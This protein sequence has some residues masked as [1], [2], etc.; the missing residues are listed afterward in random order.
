MAQPTR[1]VTLDAAGRHAPP[2]PLDPAAA[3][4]RLATPERLREFFAPRSIALVGASDSSGWG[5]FVVDSL[6]TAGFT[7]ALRPVHPKH[8]TAFD[9]PTV[10]SLRALDAPVDLAYVFAPTHAVESVLDDAA[11]AGVRNAVVLASG[12][13]DG[14][15]AQGRELERRLVEQAVARDITLLGPNCLGFVNA[16]AS[17]APFGLGIVPPLRRGPVGIVLQSGALTSNVLA[18]ARVHQVGI[19]LLTSMGNEAVITTADV[20]EHLIADDDC[21]VIGLFLESVRDAP[22][23]TALAAAAMAAGKPIVALKV[24]RTEA[25]QRTA[26][27]HTG[28]L[29][30]DDAVVDAAFRQYGVI[31]VKS[32]EELLV[33]CGLM[34]SGQVPSGRRVGV[35]T[36]SG[37]ACDII[38]D[39]ST[40]EGVEIVEF[41]PATTAALR[42]VLPPFAAAQNPLDVTGVILADR[43]SAQSALGDVALNAVVD[44]PGVDFVFNMLALPQAEPPD[45]SVVERRV[46]EVAA[47]T[48]RSR[49]PVVNFTAT[50]TDLSPYAQSLLDRHGLH[51]L[52]GIEFGLTAIGHA[53]TW[54]ETR[55]APPAV[56]AGTAATAPPGLPSG[57]WSE[58]R[59]RDLLA[60]SGVP[61]VP[62][63]LVID[64]DAAVAAALA[65]GGP[66][67]LK[68]CS[69]EITHKSDIGGVALGVSGADE[70]RTAFGRVLAAG[71]AA[72]SAIDGV[73]VSPMRAPATEL[74]VGVTVDP[75]FGPVLA[76][77]LGGVF[78]E[79]LHDVALRLLPVDPG[80]VRRMLG[81]LRGAAV[82]GGARGTRPADLDRVSEVVAGVAAAA[83]GLGP[84][85]QTLEI[86]PLR[87]DGGDVEALDV[88]V[89]TASS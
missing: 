28:A 4:R 20:V 6:R 56:G 79:V 88:L 38:A 7:G 1:S 37:G 78:I 85:L 58:A 8:P 45:P 67:A 68:I 10:P 47:T 63:E 52:G 82:L 81:E 32:L 18:F 23:F 27:A 51:A 24:G 42:A 34:G 69:A 65:F 3:R 53:L 87:V 25:G 40:D 21:E 39:R 72:T 14:G 5:R 17:V 61:L 50:C 75:S 22:R 30:G 64:A 44:D 84:A 26:L 77:G 41:A 89:V 70:V 29:A 19:S 71:R 80:Q 46:A 33:T 15:D 16:A 55:L 62:A 11:A 35:V 74:F 76:V 86:N 83:A 9:L 31:R 49:V 48:A 2:D 59:G 60:A 66:V 73:L 12:Y 36:A 57:P 13:G 54:H 43:G